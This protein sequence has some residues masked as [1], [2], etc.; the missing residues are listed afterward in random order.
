M[1]YVRAYE[2]AYQDWGSWLSSGLVDFVTI[3]DYSADVKEFE[4]WIVR[5]KEKTK[6][7]S[8]VKIAVGA[9]KLEHVPEIFEQ[10][11]RSC[12]KMHTTC[13]IF[14]YGSVWETPELYKF[15]T[16]REK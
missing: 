7:T 8:R 11:F 4:K 5:I 13:A 1:P 16:G 6:D 3:M 10:E 2:E 14:H 12:E 9:Y 15:L